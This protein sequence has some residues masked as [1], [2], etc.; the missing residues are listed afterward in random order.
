MELIMNKKKKLSPSKESKPAKRNLDV[1]EPKKPPS[2][3]PR[4]KEKK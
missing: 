2:P 3:P 1:P 4:I